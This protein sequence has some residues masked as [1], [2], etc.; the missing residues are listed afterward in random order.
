[1]FGSA[2]DVLRAPGSAPSSHSEGKG[3]SPGE[4]RQVRLVDPQKFEFRLGLFSL[5]LKP[6]SLGIS[7]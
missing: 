3:S 5:I 7:C 6:I 2:T 1:M 4:V